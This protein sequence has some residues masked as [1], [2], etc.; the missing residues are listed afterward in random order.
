MAATLLRLYIARAKARGIAVICD[1][2]MCGLGRHGAEPAEGGTGCFLSECW[3]LR[4]DCITFGKAIG[5]GAG[6]LLSGAVLLHSATKLHTVNGT[7][8]QSHTYA[9]SSARALANGAALL[10]SLPSWRS[11]VRAIGATI[12]PVLA[13]L[14]SAAG[15]AIKVHG[16]GCMWG[17][18]FMHPDRNERTRANL[19]FKAR[20]AAKGVLPYYVPVGGFMLTPRYDDEPEMLGAAV[21]D[22]ASCA[23]ETVRAM[24]WAE[25]DLIPM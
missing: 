13:E 7:A 12:G 18:V 20:C 23:L 17:G 16:Q 22:M 9:G 8:F 11:S 14:A 1:E 25:A 6:H 21:S 10:E 15:G 24:G 2:I 19:D 3:D 4:P 5:G